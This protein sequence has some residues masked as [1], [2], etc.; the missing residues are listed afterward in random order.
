MPKEND[1]IFFLNI[2]FCEL[3]NDIFK[4]TQ[5]PENSL[6]NLTNLKAFQLL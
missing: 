3:S 2:G 1:L 4:I 5:N 6:I